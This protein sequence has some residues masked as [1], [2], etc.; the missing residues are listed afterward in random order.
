VPGSATWNA[1]AACLERFGKPKVV[2]SESDLR[3]VELVGRDR[4]DLTSG[5][6]LYAL[7]EGRWRIGGMVRGSDHKLLGLTRPRLAGR[8]VFRIDIRQAHDDA[9]SLDGV[10]VHP[11]RVQQQLAV[12]CSG[13]H[14]D[15]AHVMTSC[16]VFVGGKSYWAFRGKLVVQHREL[17]VVGDRTKAGALCVQD[18]LV[19]LELD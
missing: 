1:T 9:I 11:A 4:D 13:R 18:E 15:C 12:F 6:Y 17:R 2:R 3:L 7:R 10:S 14:Q 19:S 5:T 8:E 16:D